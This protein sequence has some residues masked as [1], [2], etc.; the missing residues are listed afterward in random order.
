MEDTR[1]ILIAFLM[2]F[3]ILFA[4]TLVSGRKQQQ[5]K[6]LAQQQ[7][8]PVTTPIQPVQPVPIPA[9]TAPPS[10]AVPSAP[11]A[12]ER[13]DTLENSKLRI[14]LSSY[15]GTITSA[16]LKDYRIDLIPAGTHSAGLAL[17]TGR[18]YLDL[19]DRAMEV[20]R[21]G[22]ALEY[23]DSTAGLKITRTYQ[24]SDGYTLDTRTIVNGQNSGY[25]LLFRNGSALTEPNK[26]EDANHVILLA[27]NKTL[28]KYG[29]KQVK[30]E[31]QLNNHYRWVGMRSMY[32]L[33]AVIPQ[34]T[35]LDTVIAGNLPDRRIGWL[36]GVKGPRTADGFE[37]YFGP[38]D[39]NLL[40]C[41]G[42]QAA[43]D[44]GR[45]LVIDLTWIGLPI[46]KLLQWLFALLKNF[47]L[48]IVIFAVV[49]KGIFYPLSRMQQKQMKAMSMLQP[50]LDE[51]KKRYKN[52]SE[53]LN[54]E[55]MQLYKLYKV[56]PLS[57]CLPLLIQ[58]P[59][60][61]ALYQVLRFAVDM[62]QA[63]FVF[64]IRDLSLKDPYYVLPI[65]MG[66]F[67]ILQSLLTSAGQQNKM[68]MFMMP[69]FITVIFL[70]FP[71]GLQLYWLIFNILSII[72][73]LIVQGGL[74]WRKK[75]RSPQPT[76]A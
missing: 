2:V 39:Y 46:L 13:F 37:I 47:G 15:G 27:Q 74:K 5:Q 7:Q 38:L 68:L 72:E 59:I 34:G 76:A 4:W 16:W 9:P 26:A 51:L 60:F 3:V 20:Q 28:G 43:F 30:N 54:R 21:N 69:I 8:Q 61:F 64:W 50:K 22:P 19:S 58:M 11:K 32:F 42:L 17:P 40:H 41:C 73:S 70:N 31:L 71:S 45:F 62:R 12:P 23:S 18:D 63:P 6:S 35:T 66:V 36:A 48:A 57:G 33:T 49:V 29:A 52:D 67:S 10:A 44:F 75:P 55:T 25:F 65:L 24:L 14:V 56:N 1:R 53:G